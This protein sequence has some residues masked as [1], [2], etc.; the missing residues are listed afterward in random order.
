ML[1][2]NWREI[3]P[4]VAFDL[5]PGTTIQEAMVQIVDSAKL[6]F[7]V[8]VA[9]LAGLV[10]RKYGHFLPYAAL[11]KQL[12]EAS[13]RQELIL[14]AVFNHTEYYTYCKIASCVNQI[15]EQK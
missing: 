10:H 9:A 13:F 1:A 14:C 7:L 15:L 5:M 8:K 12:D 4:P 2:T 3:L 6:P 11:G